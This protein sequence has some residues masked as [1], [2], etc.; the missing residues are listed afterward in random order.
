MK[1]FLENIE[2]F[3]SA[4]PKE[5]RVALY[6]TASYVISQ[7]IIMLSNIKVESQVLTFGI[8]VLL[9]FLSQIKTR[10]EEKKGEKELEEYCDEEEL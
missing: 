9:V 1:K 4:L 7:A 10:M 6:I 3:W 5:V 2:L 8:N